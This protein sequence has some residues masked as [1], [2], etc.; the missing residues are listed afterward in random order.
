MMIYSALTSK[1]ARNVDA[2]QI[3]SLNSCYSTLFHRRKKLFFAS[4]SKNPKPNFLTHFTWKY[5]TLQNGLWKPCWRWNQFGI[6]P[7]VCL[8]W[9]HCIN[10]FLLWTNSAVSISAHHD[11]LMVTHRFTLL[12]P[13]RKMPFYVVLNITL[14]HGEI[15]TTLQ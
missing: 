5:I 11:I 10:I 4:E 3:S 12:L 7:F 13:V 14:F 6:V 8:L 15:Y 2:V 9:L 1:F